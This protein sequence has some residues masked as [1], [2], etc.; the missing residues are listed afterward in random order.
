MGSSNGGTNRKGIALTAAIL[1]LLALQWQLVPTAYYSSTLLAPPPPTGPFSPELSGQ[2]GLTPK[3]APDRLIEPRRLT[4]APPSPPP[5]PLPIHHIRFKQKASQAL[6]EA[7]NRALLPKFYPGLVPVFEGKFAGEV[8][9]L[10]RC[11]E[12]TPYDFPVISEA[13][14]GRSPIG[15]RKI[16]EVRVKQGRP[17]YNLATIQIMID[18]IDKDPRRDATFVFNEKTYTL[19]EYLVNDVIPAVRDLRA[20]Q[21]VTRVSRMKGD[22]QETLRVAVAFGAP[23]GH[24][25]SSQLDGIGELLKRDRR[26]GQILVTD[27]DFDALAASLG[28]RASRRRRRATTLRRAERPGADSRAVST[29]QASLRRPRASLRFGL[30]TLS[31][32]SPPRW[33]PSLRVSTVGLDHVTPEVFAPPTILGASLLVLAVPFQ[34]RRRCTPT[35][36]DLDVRTAIDSGTPHKLRSSVGA[37]VRPPHVRKHLAKIPPRNPPQLHIRAVQASMTRGSLGLPTPVQE[38]YSRYPEGHLQ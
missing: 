32:A 1:G 23:P 30:P 5:E 8:D 28:K 27:V 24:T 2:G 10:D 38:R 7:G 17:A 37:C 11:C 14:G 22:R 26:R 35:S 19:R 13:K 12:G 33:S 15:H 16:G 20:D 4:V 9:F 36:G 31:G 3:L 21:L 18:R 6:G 25:T 34:H 29:P